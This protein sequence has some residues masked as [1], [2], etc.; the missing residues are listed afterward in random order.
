[1]YRFVDRV[2]NQV[3]YTGHVFGEGVVTE[4]HLFIDM[5]ADVYVK[6]VNVKENEDKT[7]ITISV[8]YKALTGNSK[9][10]HALQK[11]LSG[12]DFFNLSAE[13]QHEAKKLVSEIYVVEGSIE[14]P[15]HQWWNVMFLFYGNHDDFRKEMGEVSTR[16]PPKKW[17][18]KKIN[19][20]Q[21]KFNIGASVLNYAE[22]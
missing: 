14:S 11:V 16:V 1:M 9:H 7:R 21:Q 18:R 19:A 3:R 12:T 17:V 4:R 13:E 15:Q 20:L 2:N 6:E 5:G 22:A 10:F 8:H